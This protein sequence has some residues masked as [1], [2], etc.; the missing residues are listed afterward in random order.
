M[1]PY[2]NDE[3]NKLQESSKLDQ[4]QSLDVSNNNNS[5]N[6]DKITDLFTG[7]SQGDVNSLV[8]M[9][10]E[11]MVSTT[12]L[13]D[14]SNSLKHLSLASK[15]PLNQSNN[16]N[17][18]SNSV[19]VPITNPLI[20]IEEDDDYQT[21]QAIMSLALN[22]SQQDIQFGYSDGFEDGNITNSS[23]V[24][25]SNETCS[26]FVV[27]V[28]DHS[29]SE[30]E[31]TS[32]GLKILESLVNIEHNKLEVQKT[33][34]QNE[35]QES[36][37]KLK[38]KEQGKLLNKE[39]EIKKKKNSRSK[40]KLKKIKDEEDWTPDKK[41]KKYSK[42]KK[43]SYK[44]KEKAENNNIN[45]ESEKCLNKS[46]LNRHLNGFIEMQDNQSS[47]LFMKD[48]LYSNSVKKF[49]TVTIPK[50]NKTNSEIFLLS[51]KNTNESPTNKLKTNS[52][53]VE[54][55][56]II[57]TEN[58]NTT[59]NTDIINFDSVL[60]KPNTF[61][62]SSS[63]NSHN[64]KY[65]LNPK[66]KTSNFC[67]PKNSVDYQK[68]YDNDRKRLFNPDIIISS[69]PMKDSTICLIKENNLVQKP[70][71]LSRS[72][73]YKSITNSKVSS[74]NKNNSKFIKVRFTND[75]FKKI[76]NKKTT[77]SKSIT[78]KHNR[79]KN[80]KIHKSDI[81]SE[82]N[83][84][85]NNTE[86]SNNIEFLKNEDFSNVVLVNDNM[87]SMDTLEYKNVSEDIKYDTYKSIEAQCELYNIKPCYVVIN[88]NMR[89]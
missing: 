1:K 35:F 47:S 51:S 83:D 63:T 46:S 59:T 17:I 7:S 2:F 31:Y 24:S 8:R 18:T 4:V 64:E 9:E 39:I 71:T 72:K 14:Y 37:I 50:I 54:N 89:Y 36:N 34:V 68:L 41:K 75:A 58:I 66:I 73:K 65:T 88:P 3:G 15:F 52:D 43:K 60:S 40:D 86:E 44:Q 53:N 25:T 48:S 19:S 57:Q 38:D 67:L 61:H 79:S 22:V 82:S 76:K 29:K 77:C 32:H 55:P 13:C 33:L 70:D 6:T 30:E 21:T 49:D 62:V 11:N 81:K 85:I 16:I 23:F 42:D 78:V 84:N 5:S 80:L 87:N 26:S 27:K 56:L 45:V 20:S 69:K 10:N 74:K 12:S 28:G